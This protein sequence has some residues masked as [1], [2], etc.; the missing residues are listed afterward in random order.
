MPPSEAA[1]ERALAKLKTSPGV[2]QRVAEEYAARTHPA[3]FEHLSPRGRRPDDLT[4]RGW[5]DAAADLPAGLAVCEATSATRW[6]GHLD[7]DIDKARACG[8]LAAFLF[9]AWAKAPDP[10]TLRSYRERIVALG[11]PA[12]SVFLVFRQQ[13]VRE[14]C[15]PRFAHLWTDPLDLRISALP[16]ERIESASQLFGSEQQADTFAPRLSEYRLGRVHRAGLTARLQ[17]RLERTD[18]ALVRGRGASGKTV[19]ATCLALGPPYRELPSYY[20]DL[21][22]A[23]DGDQTQALEVL[24]TFADDRVLF[25][26]D[27]VHLE[28]RLA[29]RFFDGW[30][31]LANGSRLLLLGRFVT[32]QSDHRGRA[33]A[34]ADLDLEAL[35]LSVEEADLAGVYRR[36][37]WR[38]SGVEAQAPPAAVLPQWER[39]FGGDLLAFS[40]AVTRRTSELLQSQWD[41]RPRDAQLYIRQEY[42]DGLV[43]EELQLLTRLAILAVIEISATPAALTRAVPPVLL[44]R[45]LVL[46]TEHGSKHNE[47]FRLV[48]PGMGQLILAALPSVD[49]L[50][51]LCELAT[52]DSF[53]GIAIA[54][55]LRSIQRDDDARAVL[56]A[57]ADSKNSLSPSFTAGYLRHTA[58]LFSTFDVLT[59]QQIEDRLLGAQEALED[60]KQSALRTQPSFFV[61]LLRYTQESLPG[62]HLF[63]SGELCILRIL[64]ALD[65]S[66]NL[67]QLTPLL[68]YAQ[69]NLPEVHLAVTGA[70]RD[71]SR[72]QL[73]NESALRTPLASLGPVLQYTQCNLPEV[74]A[75][76]GGALKEP[77]RLK[78]LMESAPGRPF[79]ALNSLLHYAQKNIPEVHTALS[80]VLNEPS[81]L[82]LLIESASSA[83][84]GDLRL[85]LQ[86]AYKNLPEIHT[87]ISGALST[88]S[89]RHALVECAFNTELGELTSFLNYAQKNLPAVH[90]AL[91]GAL[92]EERQLRAL[93]DLCMRAPLY[94]LVSFLQDQEEMLRKVGAPLR[95]ALSEPNNLELLK[96]SAL[97]VP[98]SNLA[99]FLEYAKWNQPVIY[100]AVR[101]AL[102]EPSNLVLFSK[103][104]LRTPLEH[105]ASFLQ[106]SQRNLP[107]AYAAVEA[108]L[109]KPRSLALL[110]ASAL[111][112]PLTHLSFFLRVTQ[113]NAPDFHDAVARALTEPR[114]LEWLKQSALS[115][116][117]GELTSLLQYG[118][119]NLP[120]VNAALRDVLSRPRGLELLKESV[121]HTQIGELTPFLRYAQ[122]E[123]PEV[124]AALRMAL[125]DPSR[126]T[127]LMESVLRTPFE[128]LA[129]FL[130]YA[131][132]NLPEVHA[133][134]FKAFGDGRDLPFI[135]EAVKPI[136]LANV[137]A[138]LTSFGRTDLCE[139][140]VLRALE[141]GSRAGWRDQN[142]TLV[143]LSWVARL[144]VQFAAKDLDRFLSAVATE[145][146]VARSYT[147]LSEGPLAGA[148]FALW[149]ALDRRQLARFTTHSLTKILR[150]K[151]RNS[152]C[153][154]GHQTAESL[155]LIGVGRLLGLDIPAIALSKIDD[156]GVA[157]ALDARM[158]KRS[159]PELGVLQAQIWLGIREVAQ[160]RQR[161][162]RIA[163]RTGEAFREMWLLADPIN[164]KLR[165]LNQVM[166]AWLDGCAGAGWQLIPDDEPLP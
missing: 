114:G 10:A 32:P 5:P 159:P 3:L 55:R 70:L 155:S 123:L 104:A 108:E 128:H 8:R 30:R 142:A 29:R 48:H 92:R 53:C 56:L 115:T 153:Q 158:P 157:K 63:L 64:G 135:D 69:E 93:T 87:A 36:L 57:I 34:L 66:S 144:A 13:L 148:L 145:A 138:V 111:R 42:L 110:T 43:D 24:A 102:K 15:K 26:V 139:A 96:R 140:V 37:V 16:F 80:A 72:Q 6:S 27:N 105:L 91:S 49:E 62:L 45:G 44:K 131:Q 23:E 107:E 35:D 152:L 134:L 83:A 31:E 51:I 40:A 28:P 22:D 125:S 118:Q 67:G 116:P 143:P 117:P 137:L 103:S 17:E 9:V 101:E 164:E 25:I 124:H 47:R 50:A 160:R 82:K 88:P 146:W 84:L 113:E 71:P 19:L 38:R 122:Q 61:E 20:L 54:S 4:V 79:A 121:L 163:P 130:Q 161:P 112:T 86:Y 147:R 151:L 166:I 33:D 7:K 21:T 74:Y 95:R 77:H 14:L 39:L 46:R 154:T 126:V 1:V 156:R 141:P 59:L 109:K 106:Y 52:A 97:R 12:E 165:R 60:F 149:G 127:T 68:Q 73:L 132:W 133:A 94:H 65:H 162:L 129:S 119:N 78:S 150:Q 81:N 99:R 18:W 85:F 120:E 76:L 75:A 90:A 100:A 89:Y 58:T 2:F 98:V 11:V 136:Y 41:L